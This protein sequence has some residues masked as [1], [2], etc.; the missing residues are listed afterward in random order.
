MDQSFQLGQPFYFPAKQLPSTAGRFPEDQEPFGEIAW[1]VLS[2]SR[3][4]PYDY[5]GTW[6]MGWEV[7]SSSCS[8]F[9]SSSWLKP[10][11]VDAEKIWL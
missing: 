6:D 2:L 5:G 3:D 8:R 1:V 9:I 11:V 4:G 10:W 7:A